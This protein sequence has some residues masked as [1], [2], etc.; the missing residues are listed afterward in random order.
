MRDFS[1]AANHFQRASELT[2]VKAEQSFLASRL[3]ACREEK[4]RKVDSLPGKP[5]PRIPQGGEKV[6]EPDLSIAFP[7]CKSRSFI[8]QPS[9]IFRRSKRFRDICPLLT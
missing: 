2:S 8:Q 1:A 4:E 5:P 9:Q 3:R 6:A 7:S